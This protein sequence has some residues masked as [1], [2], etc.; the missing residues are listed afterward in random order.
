MS[1]FDCYHDFHGVQILDSYLG[2]QKR[3]QRSGTPGPYI[4]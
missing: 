1:E 4:Y 2:E 3:E